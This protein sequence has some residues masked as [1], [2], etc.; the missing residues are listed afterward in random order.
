MEERFSYVYL[1]KDKSMGFYKIGISFEPI[2]REKTLQ[3]ERPVIT[4]LASRKFENRDLSKNAE[5]MLHAKYS[6]LRKRGEWFELT[7]KEVAP[8][9]NKGGYDKYLSDL[10]IYEQWFS[11]NECGNDEKSQHTYQRSVSN[12]EVWV[13][14]YCK[15]ETLTP[16]EPNEDNY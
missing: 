4:L 3:A 11:C 5:K 16:H 6:H 9:K 14:N 2:Q 8:V 1:M 10:K 7:H 13:C 12:G 15:T